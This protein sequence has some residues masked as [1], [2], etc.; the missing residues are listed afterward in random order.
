MNV[1]HTNDYIDS[2]LN[3]FNIDE[4][5]TFKKIATSKPLSLVETNIRHEYSKVGFI[6]DNSITI[7]LIHEKVE[8]FRIR[9]KLQV[10]DD[11][12]VTGID[13]DLLSKVEREI[14]EYM[15]KI[16]DEVTK[17]EV[18]KI[19]WKDKIDE[20]YSEWAIDQRMSRLKR[21][22][23]DLGFDIDIKTLYGRGYKVVKL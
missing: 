18:A 4:I 16:D 8:S 7:P 9:G 17:E 5:N 3:D 15:L 19:I 22:L 10:D 6:R 12:K 23:F 11:E 21:K 2:L 1:N 20:M 14:I 13:L